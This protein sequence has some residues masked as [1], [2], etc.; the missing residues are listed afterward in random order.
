MPTPTFWMERT[1]QQRVGFRRYHSPDDHTAWTCEAGWH[2]AVDWLSGPVDEKLDER[3]YQVQ[4]I[5]DPPDNDPRWPGTCA[6][7]DYEFV[8]DDPRQVFSVSLWRRTDTGELRVLHSGSNPP[9]VPAAEPGAMW[10]AKWMGA[11]FTGPDGIALMVRCPAP[12]HDT[13]CGNDWA[14][15]GPATGGGT[16]HRKGDPRQ[17]RVTVQPSIAFGVAGETGYYHGFLTDGQ[18]TDNLG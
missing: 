18:L 1:G 9:D 14:V 17:C 15:D 7:C 8:D 3:G 5:P 2:N 6:R 12:G 10:D 4:L 13:K 11:G 16:W